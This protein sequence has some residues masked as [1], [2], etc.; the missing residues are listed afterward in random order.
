MNNVASNKRMCA[1]AYARSFKSTLDALLTA[2][3]MDPNTQRMWVWEIEQVGQPEEPNQQDYIVPPMLFELRISPVNADGTVVQRQYFYV[4]PFMSEVA[5][6][7]VSE[8]PGTT[9]AFHDTEFTLNTMAVAMQHAMNEA[10]CFMQQILIPCAW[11]AQDGW[12][13]RAVHR[14][15]NNPD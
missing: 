12:P 8:S 15:H 2:V 4:R 7:S 1:L 11:R 9:P 5:L 6:T 10:F 13:F 3:A 14:T